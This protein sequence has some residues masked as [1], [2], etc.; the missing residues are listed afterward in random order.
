MPSVK[1]GGCAKFLSPLEAAKCGKCTTLYHRSC[2]SLPLAGPITPLWSCPECKKKMKGKQ[3]GEMYSAQVSNTSVTSN[4]STDSNPDIIATLNQFKEELRAIV[5]EELLILR[6]EFQAEFNK[7]RA[8][9]TQLQTDNNKTKVSVES[10]NRKTDGM[11]VRVTAIEQKL[12]KSSDCGDEVARLRLELNDRDQQLLA[13][14]IEIAN[15]PETN[16][17]N[18][19][20]ITKLIATKLGVQVEERDI[21]S[22]DRI[23][24]RHIDATSA[25]G[26]VE[27]RPR[28]VVVRLAR[29]SLRD[30]LIKGARVRRGA[31]T[32][33]LGMPGDRR[34]RFYVNERLTK[35][36]RYLFRR[37]RESGQRLGWKFVW[38]NR[39]RILARCKPGDQASVI[40]NEA[41][42]IRVFGQ[43][44]C[45][46]PDN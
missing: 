25:S 43:G 37:A 34:R 45:E 10:L 22:A 36:N 7:I 38:S 30:D 21:I 16:G 1:C 26:P 33:D 9:I 40:R 46:T 19:L 6:Q 44:G 29:R 18:L 35:T 27:N 24:G 14:D 12:L 13:N 42:L 11:E 2:G 39:G 31:T 5:K 20:H 4:S 17:E 23:G 15:L 41:D 28:P 3:S 8:D 32:A